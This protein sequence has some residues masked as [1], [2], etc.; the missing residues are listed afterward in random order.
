MTAALISEGELARYTRIRGENP[1]AVLYDETLEEPPRWD[2]RLRT[3]S[4][5]YKVCA[6][7]HRVSSNT[8]LRRHF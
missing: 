2:Q 5:F 1:T 6:E 4:L 8:G 7:N 3:A